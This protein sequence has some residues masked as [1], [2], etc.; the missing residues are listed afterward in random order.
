M[1]ELQNHLNMKEAD[2]KAAS[3]Q[4]NKQ[5]KEYEQFLN[6]AKMEIEGLTSKMLEQEELSKRL[7][8]QESEKEEK[9]EKIVTLEEELDKLRK[10]IEMK[11]K[12]I[13]DKE[14]QHKTEFQELLRD[15]GEECK[16]LPHTLHLKESTI[17]QYEDEIPHLQ[18]QNC[19]IV[20]TG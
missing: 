12:R 7:K 1:E 14:E 3:D 17:D 15:K 5:M 18:K 16:G 11:E 9:D 13:K 4:Q 2:T 10:V 6:V 20:T 19:Q 8:I